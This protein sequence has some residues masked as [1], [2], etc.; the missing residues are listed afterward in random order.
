MLQ[1]LREGLS[2]ADSVCNNLQ[3]IRAVCLNV[4]ATV[5][6]L[7]TRV[8]AEDT[9]RLPLSLLLLLLLL[10]V[11]LVKAGYFCGDDEMRWWQ[12]GSATTDALK[13]FQVQ[14]HLVPFRCIIHVCDIYMQ[15]LLTIYTR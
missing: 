8:V 5:K 4:F 6:H 1:S 3:P 11:S 10:Q 14:T 13:T 7:C 15:Q 9:K 12:F 2:V